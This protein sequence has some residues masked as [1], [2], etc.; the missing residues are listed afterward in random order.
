[1]FNQVNYK[2]YSGILTGTE[3]FFLANILKN[4][5]KNILY[6]AS[7]ES[8]LIY[9][10]QELKFY[11]PD[12]SVISFYS[13][14]SLPYDSVSPSN[15]NVS[16]RIK[17]LYE[18]LSSEKQKIILTSINALVQQ[19]IPKEILISRAIKLTQNMDINR[20]ELIRFLIL[21]GYVRN[22]V[23][24]EPGSFAVRGSILDICD[25]TTDKG[26]R[27]DFFGN[28]IDAIKLYD[29][30]TQLSY[31]KINQV[32]LLPISEI[33]LEDQYIKNFKENY[34]KSN[35]K[36]Y[37]EDFFYEGVVNGKKM[38][39][40][41]NYLPFF[42]H[43]KN[44]ILDYLNKST[45]IYFDYY[46]E[47][48]IGEFYN[49]TEIYYKS[50]KE[51]FG[52]KNEGFKFFPLTPNLLWDDIESFEYKIKAHNLNIITNFSS[53][54]DSIHYNFAHLPSIYNESL[55]KKI[56]V[57]DIIKSYRKNY[58]IIIF[59]T[60][61]HNNTRI[62]KILEEADIFTLAINNFSDFNK[63]SGKTIGVAQSSITRSFICDNFIFLKDEE[64]LGERQNKIVKTNKKL[65]LLLNEANNLASGE[66]VVH[67]IHGIGKFMGLQTLEVNFVKHDFILLIYE[68]GDKLFLPV[69]NIELLSKYGD[70]SQH[71]RLDKLGASNWQERK[72]KAKNRIRELATHL[73]KIAA[74]RE[75]ISIDPIV[76]NHALY[77]EFCKRFKFVETE[78]QLA[79]I[80]DIIRD[81]EGSKPIERL[82][83][84]DVGFG[85]TEIALRAAFILTSTEEYLKGQVAVVVPTTILAIQHYETFKKRFEGF[86]INIRQLSR[87]VKKKEADEIK[88]DIASGKI[89]IIIG[90]HSLLAQNINFKNLKLLILDEEQHF[91][92]AQKE[93]LKKLK[94]DI[95][96][97][98]LSATPIPRTLQMSML[99]IK[100]LSLIATPP[101]NRTAVKTH[102]L[103]YD[104]IVIKEAI[105]REIANGGKCFFVVPRISDIDQAF[106]DLKAI[107]PDIKIAI[108]HG[109]LKPTELENIMHDFSH[110]KF[111]ILISTSIIESGLDISKANTIIIYRAD[112]F[113]L[114]ALYQLRGR[115]G[116]SNQKSFAY[117]LLPKNN[118]PSKIALKRLEVMQTLDSLG[119]GFSVASYDMDIRGFGNILGEEQS[120][121]IKEI[122]I[123]LYQSMLKEVIDELKDNKISTSY[124][125]PNINIGISV[126]IPEDYIQEVD[127]RIAMYKRISLLETAEEIDNF[128]LELQ[129]RFGAYP[130][131]VEHLFLVMR[132][133][134]MC[135]A[136]NIEKLDAG[137]KAVLIVVRADNIIN[138]SKLFELLKT[139]VNIKVKPDGKLIFSR[140]LDTIEKRLKFID[141]VIA[142]VIALSDK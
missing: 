85:K 81:F 139:N 107:I 17:A 11:Y 43:Q 18:I 90:T 73:I 110:G 63:V 119:A 140:I 27:I 2:L 71:V 41:E 132:I 88:A 138:H 51:D 134:A 6:V 96:V 47:K 31:E 74:E 58:K 57:T 28:N 15:N 59:S 113:G 103:T 94:S 79:A 77:D 33:I 105:L 12:H 122:G 91:G 126:L 89:D 86:G 129:D 45:Q 93:A 7:N 1:M 128:K 4:S 55:N 39:C 66:I 19:V 50:R 108:G 29:V 60:S 68:G 118:Q 8:S 61:T 32:I 135:K 54:D 123:E 62:K 3:S 101:I 26:Y 24:S 56:P 114:S 20:E 83:C 64:I 84:G 127:L 95:H 10:A 37:N 106:K 5:N 34:Q 30:L 82:I 16:L 75:T 25:A 115:V 49:S 23:A 112:M 102:I 42:Y 100:E 99:G 76:I 38:Q 142:I 46:A 130:V 109:K 35:S 80:E 87:L 9:L 72:A 67:A 136:H 40:I 13:N 133:K 121:Q 111:D 69:E 14:D 21:I 125:S 97:I 52:I 36:F 116:R 92:V 117:L 70:D 53:S 98:T 78:D 48:A 44:T 120:G 137:E 104:K 124:W 141:E 131:E 22:E 65:E